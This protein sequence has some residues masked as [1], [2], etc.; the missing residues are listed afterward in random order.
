MGEH[1]SVV[2]QPP[3]QQIGLVEKMGYDDAHCAPNRGI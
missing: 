1:F 2:P 3:K